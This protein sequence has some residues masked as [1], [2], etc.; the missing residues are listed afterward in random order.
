[1]D[2][3]IKNFNKEME[4]VRKY[5][6]GVAELKNTKTELKNTIRGIQ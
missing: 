1:M 4:N 2:E 6:I 5:Q 3:Y